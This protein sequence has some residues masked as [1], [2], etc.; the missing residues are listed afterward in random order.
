MTKLY[1]QQLPSATSKTGTTTS[2][3]SSTVAVSSSSLSGAPAGKDGQGTSAVSTSFSLDSSRYVQSL[4]SFPYLPFVF[5]VGISIVFSCSL[6]AVL[7]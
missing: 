5:Q 1:L 3:S 2:S 7:T 6:Y 4:L